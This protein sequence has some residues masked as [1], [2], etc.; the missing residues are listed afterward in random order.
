MRARRGTPEGDQLEVLSILV[1]QYEREN[2]PVD[3]P[4]P[5]DAILFRMEQ[6]GLSRKD[7]EPILGGRSH[8]SEILSGKRQLTVEMIRQLHRRFGIPLVSLMGPS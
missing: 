1:E 7:L 4:D 5:I 2:F 6:G 3:P 8:V